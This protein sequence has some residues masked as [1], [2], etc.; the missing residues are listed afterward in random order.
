M[1]LESKMDEKASFKVQPQELDPSL[2]TLTES[3]SSGGLSMEV[4]DENGL[5]IMVDDDDFDPM[6][7]MLSV[8]LQGGDCGIAI[9]STGNGSPASDGIFLSVGTSQG[10]SETGGLLGDNLS[11]IGSQPVDNVN[12]S[13]SVPVLKRDCRDARSQVDDDDMSTDAET[14]I[15]KSITLLN[16]F[17]LLNY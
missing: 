10:T 7:D 4:N 5:L 12:E 14:T 15:T 9:G 6:E 16:A 8:D 11:V 13:L 17:T 1:L 3:S 2:I